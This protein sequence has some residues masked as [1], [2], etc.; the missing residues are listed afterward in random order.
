MMLWVR[1]SSDRAGTAVRCAKMREQICPPN[2]PILNEQ[3]PPPVAD[4]PAPKRHRLQRL[5]R[6]V[7]PVPPA[8]MARIRASLFIGRRVF[9]S[10]LRDASTAEKLP[11]RQTRNA[12][13]HSYGRSADE[14]A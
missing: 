4:K 7:R 6:T 9:N 1:A 8:G 3:A 12:I 5:D 13:E 2:L 11:F 10:P 14:A